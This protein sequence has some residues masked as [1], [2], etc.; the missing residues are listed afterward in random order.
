[1]ISLDHRLIAQFD[2]QILKASEHLDRR[3]VDQGANP[4]FVGA[5]LRGRESWQVKP[6][7]AVG[8]RHGDRTNP[9]QKLDFTGDAKFNRENMSGGDRCMTAEIDLADRREPPE[10]PTRSFPTGEGRL[11][12]IV[13]HG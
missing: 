5:Y 13:L 10:P 1:N 4:C 3:L 2:E 8:F 11:G 7:K 9:R 12:Q 6:I